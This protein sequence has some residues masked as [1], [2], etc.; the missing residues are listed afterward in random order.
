MKKALSV[1]GT[2]LMCLSINVY[3][4]VPATDAVHPSSQP[5]TSVT[6]TANMPAHVVD[7]HLHYLDFLQKS[8]GFEKLVKKMDQTGVEKAV[9]FGMAMAKEWDENAPAAPAYYLSND[10]RCYYYSGTDHLMLQ[11]L[12]LQPKAVRDRFYPFVCGINTTDRYAAQ[13]LRQLFQMYPEIKGIGE[14]MSRHDDLT[15]L[16]YGEPP[17][18]DSPALMAVYDLAAEYHVPVLIHH[19]IAG[20]YMDNP[21][22]LQEMKN[23]LAHNRNTNIIWA[24]VGISR[25]VEISN[26]PQI[27]DQMLKENKNL[28]YDISWV[29]YDDY[30]VKN[31]NS[32]KTWAALIEKYPDRFMVGS[33]KV[34]HW[35]TYSNE[36]LK[37]GKLVQYLKPET[38]QNLCANNI[39]RLVDPAAVNSKMKLAG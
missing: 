2:L 35:D 39:Y 20:S 23:A 17:H 14:V 21:I 36:I 37:Y 24:H 13:Q 38:A 33:D 29:V 11:A 16:T 9:I 27:A 12:R 31:E 28:Y 34:G 1:F 5:K 19:N 3:A 26:L 4:A 10:S 15:A 25:R 18:A 6:Q 32:L 7:S 22:Y 30:I 8:D